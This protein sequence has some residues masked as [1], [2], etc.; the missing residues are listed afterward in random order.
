MMND[1]LLQIQKRL[2]VLILSLGVVLLVFIGRLGYI[3]VFGGNDIRA[4][5]LDLWSREI[6]VEG[7]RGTIYD[8]NGKPIV[9]N[10]IAPSV[11]L[12]PRQ[13]KDKELTAKYLS[14]V[15]NV[16]FDEMMKHVNKNVSVELVKPEGR[17]LDV[18]TAEKIIE[19]NLPG[20][21]VVGDTRRNYIYGEYLAHVLGF[22]GADNQGITGI[23]FMYEEYLKGASGSSKYYVDARGILLENLYGY[24]EA[25]SQGMDIYLTIDIELQIL[26]EKALENA[27]AVYQPDQ[28]MGMMMDPRTGEILAMA[29]YPSFDPGDYQKYPQEVYNRNLPIWM[30]FE[31]GSTFKIVTYSAGLEEGVFDLEDTFFDPGYRIVEDR[32][33]KDWKAGG[34]GLQTFLEVIENSC[35]PGFMEIGDRLGVDRLFHYI[36]LYGFNE[37]TGVDLL[38]ESKGIVFNPENV[39][40]V[41]L[42]TSSFGQGNSVTPIQLV[43][44]FSASINGGIL[45]QPYALKEVRMPITNDVAY[46]AKPKPI[47]R[48]ISEETSATMRYA[49]ESVVARGTGGNAF[50]D[51]LRIG[52]KTGTAQKPA[53]GGGYLANNYIVSFIGGAPMNDPELVVFVAIDYPKNTIQYGGV[54]AAPIVGEIFEEAFHILGLEKQPDQIEKEYRWGDIRYVEVPDL[55]GKTRNELPPQ[56]FFHYDIFGSGEKVVYQSPQPG[57]KIVEGGHIY[58][59]MN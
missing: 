57:E 20:V 55:I 32:R 8:R 7:Q 11:A 15:L 24:Y 1:Q 33:I 49:L 22:V 40:P 17:K 36:D 2:M 59:Y 12:I 58:L 48:V 6:P 39:G 5:A 29:S 44:A 27:N 35:N 46:A 26:L 28:M 30:T 53:E 25:P 56:I 21:Y 13:I 16:T 23:E 38:G 31:P 3:Q 50:R 45:Y 54:V 14:D 19:K 51:G 52:G 10:I 9:N 47:R 18:Q 37:K 42:A 34:H 4:R 43:R 41:E